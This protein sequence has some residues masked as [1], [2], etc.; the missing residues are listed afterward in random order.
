ML[1]KMYL[2]AICNEDKRCAIAAE[3]LLAWIIDKATQL[4]ARLLLAKEAAS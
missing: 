2:N 3:A 1:S 4:K